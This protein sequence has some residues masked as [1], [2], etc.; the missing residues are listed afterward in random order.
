MERMKILNCANHFIWS[1]ACVRIYYNGKKTINLEW[2]VLHSSVGLKTGENE[3]NIQHTI[4]LMRFQHCIVAA[5]FFVVCQS[6][7]SH[8]PCELKVLA[9]RK[10]VAYKHVS[11]SPHRLDPTHSLQI[12]ISF[13][14]SSLFRAHF[15]HCCSAFVLYSSTYMDSKLPLAHFLSTLCF[16]LSTYPLFFS[17]PQP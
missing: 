16:C 3:A 9:R 17:P 11:I 12:N 8:L 4:E 13:W 2:S 7:W 1:I 5:V 15:F 10:F 6:K 14:L